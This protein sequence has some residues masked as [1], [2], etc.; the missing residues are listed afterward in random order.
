MRPPLPSE[1]AP[2]VGIFDSGLGG[3]SVLRA[4]RDRLP[5]H[6]LL[7]VADSGHAPYGER[8]EA[9]VIKRS[10]AI[11]RF[12]LDQG[13]RCVVVACNTATTAAVAT[14]RQH[15]PSL[16]IVGV[17]PGLKPA[18]S[19]TRNQRIGVMATTG[20]LRSEKFRLLA[21]AHAAHVEL[22]L[23]ACPGLASAIEG[24][25]IDA[26]HVIELVR[27]HCEPL[28]KAQVDTVVLGCTHYPFVR[29]HIQAVLGPDVTLIDTADAVARQTAQLLAALEPSSATPIGAVHAP[30]NARLWTSGDIASLQAALQQWLGWHAEV[31]V[32]PP[33]AS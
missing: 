25:D 17:E 2:R 26:P 4:I 12:L 23:Q 14:L 31:L 11:S 18:V 7:Y 16:A 3:L 21:Q 28:R 1:A 5:H 13:A 33:S 20:T 8:S 22:V 6:E 32:L 15:H 9:F 30:S 10:L 29:H 19:A 27:H 24:G